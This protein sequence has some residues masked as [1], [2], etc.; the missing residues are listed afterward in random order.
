M[1]SIGTHSHYAYGHLIVE[2]TFK[3]SVY[4]PIIFKIILVHV[5]H[6]HIFPESTLRCEENVNH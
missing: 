3:T 2:G 5:A 4:N 6:V 1:F